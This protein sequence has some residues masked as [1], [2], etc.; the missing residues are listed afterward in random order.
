M[1]MTSND[2]LGLLNTGVELVN[3]G[4]RIGARGCFRAVLEADPNNE[5][6]VLWL[7]YLSIDPF[8]AVELLENF[9]R[10]NPGSTQAQSY[11]AQARSRCQELDQLVTGSTTFNTWT[12]KGKSSANK[13][14]PFLGEY[15]L[16]Q[17]VITQQQLEMALRRHQDLAK[18]GSRKRVGEVMIELGYINQKQLDGWL[19]QQTGDYSYQFRD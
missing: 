8:K 19:Q 15:L 14:V 17:G 10:R 1:S 3:T 9:L 7:A 16:K 4:D 2:L 5:T 11:L 13:A 18:R 12:N 6:A